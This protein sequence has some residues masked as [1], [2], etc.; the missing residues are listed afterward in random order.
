MDD[1]TLTE[2]KAMAYDRIATMDHL[3]AEL[4]EINKAIS[5]KANENLEGD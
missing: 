2:L 5:T 4:T 3:R 1:K